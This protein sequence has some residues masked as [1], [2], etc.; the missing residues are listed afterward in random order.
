M[1]QPIGTR[2]W[3]Q[4]KE[5]CRDCAKIIEVIR[6]VEE[7]EEEVKCLVMVRKE[8]RRELGK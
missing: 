8:S 2:F 4:I 1:E 3:G 7:S 5:H 6:W